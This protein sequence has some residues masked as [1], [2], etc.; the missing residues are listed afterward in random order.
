MPKSYLCIGS[1]TAF[2]YGHE[3]NDIVSL[4]D[5]QKLDTIVVGDDL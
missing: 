4:S 2:E 1:I 5:H 3:D